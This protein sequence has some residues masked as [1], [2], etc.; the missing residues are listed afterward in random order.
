MDQLPA[1]PCR[2]LGADLVIGV[3][4]ARELEQDYSLESGLDIIRRTNSITRSILTGLQRQE[5]DLLI[6]PEVGSLSWIRFDCTD[7]CIKLGETAAREAL[8][9]IT[10]KIAAMEPSLISRLFTHRSS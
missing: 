7:E 5:A 4:V 2:R 1:G 8:P 9:A 3:D 10:D 6:T